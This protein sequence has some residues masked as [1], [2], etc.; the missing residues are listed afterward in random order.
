MI[1]NVLKAAM[2]LIDFS[3]HPKEPLFH[4]LNQLMHKILPS[5]NGP[6]C[7]PFCKHIVEASF[8]LRDHARTDPKTLFLIQ[9]G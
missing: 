4:I 1:Y 5:P 7:V 9:M 3:Y 8:P 2:R 6:N